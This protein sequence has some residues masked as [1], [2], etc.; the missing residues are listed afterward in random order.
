MIWT[1]LL[2]YLLI[3]ANEFTIVVQSRFL[4]TS[5]SI[6]NYN[7]DDMVIVVVALGTIYVMIF[8]FFFSILLV[9]IV[10]NLIDKL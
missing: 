3:S 8:H 5:F 9:D 10:R 7:T 6:D 2:I 4:S 1:E